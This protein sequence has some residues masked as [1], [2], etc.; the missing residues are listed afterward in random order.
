MDG[1]CPIHGDGS[2]LLCVGIPIMNKRTF[3]LLLSA[4]GVYS[5]VIIFLLIVG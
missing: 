5:L 4:L 3:L 2:Q 1:T